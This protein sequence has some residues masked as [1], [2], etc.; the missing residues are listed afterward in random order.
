MLFLHIT[1]QTTV[2]QKKTL[3]IKKP[4][5]RVLKRFFDLLTAQSTHV[6]IYLEVS[7]CQRF[8]TRT[9]KTSTKF[10]RMIYVALLQTTMQLNTIPLQSYSESRFFYLCEFS[11]VV[12]SHCCTNTL[13]IYKTS[14]SI[15]LFLE[16]VFPLGVRLA[17]SLDIFIKMLSCS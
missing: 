9:L 3:F 6:S 14:L 13:A 15:Y 17:F 7:R 4:L 10:Y 8:L 11:Y 5:M 16:N 2:I 1:F 12:I